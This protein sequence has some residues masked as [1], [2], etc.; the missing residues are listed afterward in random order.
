MLLGAR[1]ATWGFGF[2]HGNAAGR[3]V[4]SGCLPHTMLSLHDLI[5]H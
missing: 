2:V 4:A 3:Q 5:C 1:R